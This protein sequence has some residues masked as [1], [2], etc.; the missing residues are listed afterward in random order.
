MKDLDEIHDEG[1]SNALLI[2]F[3]SVI[4]CSVFVLAG[5]ALIAQ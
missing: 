5:V 1:T 3:W 2:I 4:F